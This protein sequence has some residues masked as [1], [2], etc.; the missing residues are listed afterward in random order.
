MNLTV[1]VL[2]I[3]L[4]VLKGI[5]GLVFTALFFFGTVV[6]IIVVGVFIYLVIDLLKN[7]KNR[8]KSND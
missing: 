6:C 5:Y 3:L 4:L 7:P 1:G 8:G 2:K